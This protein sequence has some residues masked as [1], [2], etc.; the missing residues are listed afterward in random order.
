MYSYIDALC[1]SRAVFLF[2]S[3][4]FITLKTAEIKKKIT[5]G[6]HLPKTFYF[7]GPSDNPI[8]PT[9]P[10]TP[11]ACD[12]RLTF[13]AITTLRGEILFFK[14]KYKIKLFLPLA[15]FTDITSSYILIKS[16]ITYYLAFL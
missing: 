4:C 7:L 10:S 16:H 11:T 3:R 13:D 8:Q 9:G 1:D 15:Y 6:L 5:L 12:P 14:D 2:V